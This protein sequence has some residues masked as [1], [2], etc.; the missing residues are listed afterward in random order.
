MHLELGLWAVVLVAGRTDEPEWSAG[1]VK[2]EDSATKRRHVE[3]L[4]HVVIVFS[5]LCPAPGGYMNLHELFPALARSM[6]SFL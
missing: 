4:L 3:A 5:L 1:P 2:R 6:K